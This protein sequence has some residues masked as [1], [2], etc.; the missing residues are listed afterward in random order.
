MSSVAMSSETCTKF[1]TLYTDFYS[2][3]I[4][5]KLHIIQERNLLNDL[6]Q[7]LT[8]C[9]IDLMRINTDESREIIDQWNK[10]F[11]VIVS[12]YRDYVPVNA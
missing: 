9:K 5:R 8:V 2:L 1:H 12:L 11:N 3:V 4:E 7:S 10:N 6:E